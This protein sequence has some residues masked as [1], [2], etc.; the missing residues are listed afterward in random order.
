[1]SGAQRITYLVACLHYVPGPET[2]VSGLLYCPYDND[3][4][5]I[6]GVQDMEW[7][8]RCT[9][10]R[11]ARWAGMS[12]ETAGIFITGHMRRNPGHVAYRGFV[13]NSTAAATKKKFEAWQN[14]S[15][16]RT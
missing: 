1:M 4:S 2:L 6:I 10:C 16:H 9:N 15:L 5:E 8:A 12:K 13:I 11:Y 3:Y 14:G 7:Q